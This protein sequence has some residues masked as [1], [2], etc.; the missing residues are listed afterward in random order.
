LR[1]ID[2]ASPYIIMAIFLLN[3]GY[4]HVHF[5][6]LFSNE[7]LTINFHILRLIPTYSAR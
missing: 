1:E 7:I 5:G 6:K 4:S 2:S 3:R